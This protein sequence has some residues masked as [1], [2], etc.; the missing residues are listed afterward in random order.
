MT[1]NLLNCINGKDTALTP[2]WLM[3]QAGRYLP[4]Y[5][6]VRSQVKSFLELC[7]NVDLATT[8]TLQPLKRFQ[9]DAAIVFSDILVVPEA[10]GMSLD[11]I[12]GYGP[13][14]SNPLTTSQDIENLDVSEIISKLSY[15]YSIIANCKANLS[16]DTPLIGFTGSPFTLACYMIEG[17]GG[18]NYAKTKQL[19]YNNSP[20][21]HK[22]LSKLT[23]AGTLHLQAQIDAGAD[24]VMLFDS[25]GG[26]L[27]EDAYMSY[28]QYYLQ[29]VLSNL[30]KH[31]DATPR[32]V[33]TKGSGSW[34]TL[35]N[36]LSAQVIGI[37][38]HTDIAYARTLVN[39]QYCVQGNF[40]PVLL[41]IASKDVIYKEVSRIF[42]R[43]LQTNNNKKN[44]FIF[45][46][47]HGIIPTTP[48]D[49]VAYLVDTVHNISSK[50]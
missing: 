21:F 50:Y 28:S 47:G 49:N 39:P 36:N 48:P 12:E 34:L 46:L 11:F 1:N 42:Q 29:Q 6:Q 30:K 2:I 31:C 23:Q 27:T 24:I 5:R 25:C 41:S 7:K 26:A 40:D 19:M 38:W 16:I 9:L 37:D 43:Y 15:V 32:I 14:F 10:M 22:L 18:T 17:N 44:N 3:R 20:L 33:F 8:V 4:E 45:N 13:K 35:M